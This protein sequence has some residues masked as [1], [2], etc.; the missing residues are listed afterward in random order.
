MSGGFS[1]SEWWRMIKILFQWGEGPGLNHLNLI[2]I[3][4][5]F[6]DGANQSK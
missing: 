2:L 5:R 6:V 1:F 4:E 3:R